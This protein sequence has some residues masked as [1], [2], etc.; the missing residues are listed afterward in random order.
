MNKFPVCR[1]DLKHDSI[2]SGIVPQPL[3]A[4]TQTSLVL[5]GTVLLGM[6][7]GL[8]GTFAYLRRRALAGDVIAHAALPGLCM[9]FLLTQSR[10]I[11]VLL[12]GAL[13]TGVI[14]AFL[15]SL[16]R[17]V[18]RLR[19]DAILGTVLSI[20]YGLGIALTRTI[21]NNYRNDRGADLES[22]I[23]GRAAT[24]L[25]GD[26]LQIAVVAAGCSIAVLVTFKELKLLSFDESFC[27]V[28]GW[29]ATGLDLLLMFLTAVTVIA[30]LPAVG[31]VLT[32]ALLIIPAAAARFWT[33]RLSYM[34]TVSAGI[35]GVSGATGTLFSA[36]MTQMP[37]G[38]LVVLTSA[39]LFV[40]SWMFAPKRGWL[41]NRGVSEEEMAAA[42]EELLTAESGSR[43]GV[44]P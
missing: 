39:V 13:V 36:N 7:A 26:V 2:D 23:I 12:I 16:L 43:I 14:G 8:V 4:F 25:S 31:V 3:T 10:S 19:E 11:A 22:F 9:A 37:T 27:R 41:W 29:P 28:Q 38:P 1:G 34:M 15:M 33:D 35:G 42:A 32:A 17:R 44:S 40:I 6:T 30:G 18:S 5:I 20:S 24:M 21:Q